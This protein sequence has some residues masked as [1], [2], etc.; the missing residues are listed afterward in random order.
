MKFKKAIAYLA[1]AAI[2]VSSFS[3]NA[4]AMIHF[5]PA[6][7]MHPGASTAGNWLVQVYRKPAKV[8]GFKAFLEMQTLSNWHIFDSVEVAYGKETTISITM[9]SETV[10]GEYAEDGSGVDGNYIVVNTDIPYVEGMTAEITSFV[11]DGVDIEFGDAVLTSEG[12]SSNKDYTK[13]RLT[14]AN[15]W[16]TEI[17]EQPVDPLTL[18]AFTKLDVSFKIEN[19]YPLEAARPAIDYGVDP[20]DIAKVEVTLQVDEDSRDTFEGLMGGSVV[21]SCNGESFTDEEWAKYNWPSNEWW[22]VVDEALG[23]DTIAADKECHAEKIGDYTYKVIYNVPEADRFIANAD[24]YQ[25]GIQEWGDTENNLTVTDLTCYGTAGNKIISYDK[26]GNPTVYATG[27]SVS[28]TASSIYFDETT[29]LTAT[30][31]PSGANT[32]IVWT[33]SDSAVATV[34]DGVVS[35]VSEGTVTITA[36]TNG[37]SD[38]FTIDV[39]GYA[40]VYPDGEYETVKP[41]EIEKI[42]EEMVKPEPEETI[43]QDTVDDTLHVHKT[44]K[45]WRFYKLF[46]EEDLKGKE[47]AVMFIKSDKNENIVRIKCKNAYAAVNGVKAPEGYVYVAFTISDVPDD[48]TFTCTD[49]VLE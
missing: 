24:V 8:D 34:E 16:N 46:K 29:T 38:T 7:E 47:N 5:P 18:P 12:N 40:D 14:L 49:I 4:G 39:T 36:T 1:S 44:G 15:K 30:C 28:G 3:V 11:L 9:D 32:D 25:V 42:E 23:I 27:I 43:V 48:V 19:P 35:G 21:F 2:M 41:E 13:L 37:Y 33:T 45:K 22:G 17:T 26:Y 10:F 20:T 6:S 31:T